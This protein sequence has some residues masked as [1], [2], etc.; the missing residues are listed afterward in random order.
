MFI[1]RVLIIVI[2]DFLSLELDIINPGMFQTC[3]CELIIH[4]SE[5]YV[6]HNISTAQYIL[7]RL[8]TLY[9]NLCVLLIIIIDNIRYRT[10]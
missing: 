6:L 8:L 4:V 10:S 9:N 3:V 1:L 7:D 2:F 5:T